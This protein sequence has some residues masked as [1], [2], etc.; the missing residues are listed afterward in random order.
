MTTQGVQAH[1]PPAAVFASEQGQRNGDARE[2][3]P[4][5]GKENSSLFL[6]KKNPC[7]FPP[8]IPFPSK[9]R[10]WVHV[11][12]DVLFFAISMPTKIIIIHEPSVAGGQTWME[13]VWDVTAAKHALF[14]EG[15]K[16][17]I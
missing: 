6:E 5:P 8:K 4:R 9:A 11:L 13:I 3:L 7:G 1:S 16:C 2:S 12:R 14:R 15:E 17:A 10:V